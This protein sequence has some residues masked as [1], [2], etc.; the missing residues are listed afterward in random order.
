TA[1]RRLSGP[2][3]VVSVLLLLV[4]LHPTAGSTVYGA[5]RW[6][7]VGPLTLQPSE[8]AKLALVAFTAAV[9][10]KKQ[11]K[12]DDWLHL[13]LPLGPVVIVVAGIV[14]MQRDLGTT[15]VIVGSV[16]MMLFVGG[17]RFRHLLVT[18]IVALG[19]LAILIFGTAY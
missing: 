16:L 4:A 11:G 5:S 13:A 1:W 12:L 15:I 10:S 2:F 9:L 7:A 3:L 19:G 18:G 6:I 17:A 8:F 14:M